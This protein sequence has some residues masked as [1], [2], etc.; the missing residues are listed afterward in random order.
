MI[1]ILPHN[2]DYEK[3]ILAGCLLYPDEKDTALE[4]LG[5]EDFY[6]SAHQIIFRA[7]K[8]LTRKKEPVDIITVKDCIATNDNSENFG[9]AFL[10]A[11]IINEP[12]PSNTEHYCL[13]VKAMSSARKLI[14]TCND[15]SKACFEP[16]GDYEAILDKAQADI[17]SVDFGGKDNFITMEDLSIESMERYEAVKN[18][19]FEMGI[20][21]GFHDLDAVTGG[22]LKGSKFIII[23]ARPR[24]G[25]TAF[26]LCLARNIARRGHRVGI[27]EIEMDKEELDD[28]LMAMETGFNTLKFTAGRGIKEQADWDILNN[29]AGK[30]AKWQIWIDDTGGL[31]IQELKRRSRKLKKL[32]VEIIFIDQ[33]SKITGGHGRSEYE[34][35]TDIVN[36]LAELKKE[37]RMPVVLLAQVNRKLEDRSNKAPTLG[38]LKA[39]GSL[40]EDSDI[41]LLGHRPYEYDKEKEDP[42]LAYWEVA[43]NRGGPEWMSKMRWDPKKTM[44]QDLAREG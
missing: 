14:E 39:T 13:K 17:L 28:R 10:L 33:L 27:F 15:I 16:G 20:R 3:S 44:F 34:K 38:D 31:S 7:V 4:I 11:E 18:G 12:I 21:T 32:G 42:H 8:Y 36:Q 35:K 5:H 23:A 26:M 2:L 30:K 9:G 43:K 40:E 37:L 1:G 24:I 22:G 25:K 29:A 41:I 19:T 6:R